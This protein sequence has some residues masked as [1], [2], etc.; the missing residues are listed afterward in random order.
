[1]EADENQI[2]SNDTEDTFAGIRRISNRCRVHALAFVETLLFTPARLVLKHVAEALSRR[3][4]LLYLR[5]IL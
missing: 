3:Y 4:W 5:R 2:L 1:M